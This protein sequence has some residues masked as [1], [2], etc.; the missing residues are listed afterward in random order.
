MDKEIVFQEKPTNHNFKDIEGQKFNRLLVLGYAGNKPRSKWWCECECGIVCV[1]LSGDLASGG[2]SSCGCLRNDSVR[3]AVQ[4][5]GKSLSCLHSVWRGMRGRCNNPNNKD[6]HNY[7]G[8]EKPIKV[9]KRWDKFEN[10]YEDM[11]DR[12]S[13]NH[14]IDR[15][16]NDGDYKP[17]NCLWVLPK[18]QA[19]NTRANRMLT[20]NG[21]THCLTRWAEICGLSRAALS[22][23]I[24]RYNWTVEDALTK[25]R[26]VNQFC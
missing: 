1:V 18:D 6:Y 12:P 13:R 22:C 4:K 11:G 23:R 14:S 19:R 25:P 7:G 3:R 26:Q 15:T 17:G 20:F 16:D 8:R 2:T 9:C 24:N 10:F 21:E 5:H